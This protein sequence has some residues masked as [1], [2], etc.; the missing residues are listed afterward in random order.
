[1]GV[2]KQTVDCF[3]DLKKAFDS[4][5]HDGLLFKL[6]EIQLKDDNIHLIPSIQTEMI[7]CMTIDDHVPSQRRITVYVPHCTFLEPH[8]ISIY[9]DNV[10]RDLVGVQIALFADDTEV[11]RRLKR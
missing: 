11:H 1:M 6:R 3:L 8:L 10:P 5:C 4:V 9:V 2:G 7:F